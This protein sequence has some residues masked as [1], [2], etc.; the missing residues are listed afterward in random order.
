MLGNQ[1]GARLLILAGL[2]VIIA[3]APVGSRATSSPELTPA[4]LPGISITFEH[5]GQATN[6]MDAR[7]A[8]HSSVHSASQAG[9]DVWLKI[10]NSSDRVVEFSTSSVYLRPLSE[11]DEMPDRTK[12]LSLVDG[13]EISVDFGVEDAR[14]R[15]VPYGSDFQWSSRLKPG[16][17]AYFSVPRAALE[18][19]GSIYV[20][21]TAEDPSTGDKSK[22]AY[23]VYFRGDQLPTTEH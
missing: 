12:R 2:Q 8:E 4:V 15:D 20:A 7:M 6:P 22:E 13:A 11:W 21:F 10:S 1:V 3:C 19:H 9:R 14:G 16:A 18:H 5:F 23:R 17:A